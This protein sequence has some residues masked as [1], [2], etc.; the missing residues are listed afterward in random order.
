MQQNKKRVTELLLVED[1]LS[2][3]R[4]TREVLGLWSLP[5]NLSVVR[6]GDEALSFLRRE[7]VYSVKPA[8]NLVLL[9]LN[10][11]GKSGFELL[12]EIK[13]DAKLRHIPVI[14]LTTSFMEADVR[15]AYDAHANCY[16]VKPIDLVEFERV[17]RAIENFWLTVARL[18]EEH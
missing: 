7:G 16:I 15:K 12:G 2:D 13:R 11:P 17:S 14:V 3:I 8:I 5:H 18:P 4:L 10:L 1:D 9:D 6:T